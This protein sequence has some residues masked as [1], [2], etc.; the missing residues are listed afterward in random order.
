MSPYGNSV[1]VR[2]QVFMERVGDFVEQLER[3]TFINL[4]LTELRLATGKP[5]VLR[6]YMS[7]LF[8]TLYVYSR[9]CVHIVLVQVF[10]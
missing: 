4:F 8:S 5:F 1:V 7:I 6:I 9:T 3:V 10:S 2:L